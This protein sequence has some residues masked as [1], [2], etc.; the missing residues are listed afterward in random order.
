M[1]LRYDFY[2]L[3]LKTILYFTRSFVK[4]CFYHSKIKVISS[5]RRV[6]LY[7]CNYMKYWQRYIQNGGL[8]Q[9]DFVVKTAVGL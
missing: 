3:V 1:F 5:R 8:K 6:I 2:L 7:L 4:Y 9:N